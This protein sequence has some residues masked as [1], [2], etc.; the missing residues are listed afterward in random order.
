MKDYHY[1]ETDSKKIL[2]SENFNCVFDKNDGTCYTWGKTLEEDVD[3]SPFG[4]LIAD[5][6]I[7][8]ICNGVK[9][10][11]CDCCYKKNSPK[12]ENMSFETL[13]KIVDSFPPMIQQVAFGVSSC[14]TTNPE[15]EKM[16]HYCNEKQIKPN[17]TI[18]DISNETAD[19]IA[20]NCGAVAVS[21]YDDKNVCYDNVKMLTDRKMKQTNIHFCLY[22]DTYSRALEVIDDI[23]NDSRLIDMNAIVFLSLK[24]KGRGKKLKRINQHKFD[25]LMKKCIDSNIKFGMD[26]CSGFK[27]ENFCKENDKLKLLPMIT[28]CEST[29]QSVYF[30]CK[31]EYYPCS[32]CEGERDWHEGINIDDVECF[33]KDVWYHERVKK[34]R[35]TITKTCGNCFMFDV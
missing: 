20:E 25:I 2:N 26:S 18:A 33:I 24:N 31:G 16:L 32:F 11:L 30:N 8:S 27:F 13:K 29:L 5:I 4:P 14:A 3:F 21:C 23:K 28:N 9:G 34:F 7:S 15:F 22:E 35:D 17:L 12:G 6:E 10:K 19:M 1:K